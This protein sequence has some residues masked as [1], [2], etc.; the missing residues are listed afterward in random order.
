MSTVATPVPALGAN[1]VA[2]VS[3][4]VEVEDESGGAVIVVVD[5]DPVGATVVAVDCDPDAAGG[6]GA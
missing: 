1:V 4:T 5:S 6:G 2:V 3:G